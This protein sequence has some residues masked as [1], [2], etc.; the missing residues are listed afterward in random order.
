MSDFIHLNC[1]SEYSVK[2]GTIR[3][4]QLVDKAKKENFKAVAIT[5]YFNLSVAIKF[6]N[7]AISK[8]IKPIFGASIVVLEDKNKY[9]ISLLCQN[10]SGYLNLCKLISEC[11]LYHQD[12][13]SIVAP[14]ELV[15]KYNNG[16]I[17][18]A[19]AVSC[20]IAQ[21]LLDDKLDV[22]YKKV[23]LWQ[24]IFT[25]RYY[26]GVKRTNLLEDEKHLQLTLPLAI[27]TKTP[28]VATN[29]V[30]FLFK[31]DFYAYEARV[32][33][34]EG[35]LLDDDRRN[36]YYSSEQYL[37]SAQKMSELFS[38]IPEAIINSYQIAIRCNVVFDLY[39]K[40]YY[41]PK[42]PLP[43]GL[44]IESFLKKSSLLGLK[45]RLTGTELDFRAYKKRLEYELGV[46]IK[47]KF[48]GYFLIVADFIDFSKKSNI[49]VG[50]GRGS[51]A[52]SLVAY[53]LYITNVDPIRHGLLFERFLNPERISMPD[54]DIDFCTDR[55]DDVIDYVTKKYGKDKV[56]QIIT[57]GTM[58]AKAVVRD[59]GRVLGHPYGF[60]DTLAK[61][62]PNDL[63]ITLDKALEQSSELRDKYSTIEDVK[64]LIDV[65]KKLEGLSRN[66][67]THAGGVVIAPSN[68]SDFCPIY[69]GS[70]ASDSVVTQFDKDDIEAIG[71]VKFDF[72]G[73]GNLTVIAKT[74]KTLYDTNTIKDKIDLDNIELNDKAVYE[75]LQKA[76][77]TGVFQLESQGMR[78]YLKKLKADSF[79]DIVAMLALYRPGPL[80]SG[81][82]DDYINVKHGNKIAQYPHKMLEDILQ[83]TN[84]VFVYQEQVMQ[85]AQKMAGYSLGSADLLRRVMGKKQVKEMQKQRSVFVE[86]ALKKGIIIEKANEIFDL[87]DKFS[88][89]GFNKSHSVAYALISY[90]TAFLKVHYPAAFMSA[91]LSGVMQDTTRVATIVG[92]IKNMSLKVIAPSVNTSCYEFSISGS[93]IIYGLGAIKGL[94]RALANEIVYKRE[95]K[96]YKDLVDFCCRINRNLLNKRAV[97]TLILSGSFDTIC[98][99]R[100]ELLFNYPD[101]IL[102]A[103]RFQQDS[104]T[105]QI[106]LFISDVNLVPYKD[107]KTITKPWQ[108]KEQLKYEKSVMGYYFSSHPC[109][110]EVELAKQISANLPST[111]RIRNNSPVKILGLVANIH[112]RDTKF[113]QIATFDLVDASLGI[114]IF[115]S[116]K[117]LS[118]METS[119]AN[120]DIIVVNGIITKDSKENWQVKVAKLLT[121][122]EVKI[123]Q[124]KT[125]VIKLE[126][127]HDKNFTNLSKLIKQYKGECP[128]Y[129]QY[130][131]NKSIGIIPLNEEYNA[132]PSTELQSKIN[133]LLKK[134]DAVLLNY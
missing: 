128:V 7:Y 113:G 63:G 48:A 124:I 45:K 97:E 62:I 31:Q 133:N 129:L 56:T 116:S 98:A 112:Y 82:V 94:G 71:L 76:D 77:T 105:G 126:T 42:F 115:L 74:L 1:L 118:S 21:L 68:I 47:M 119:I 78:A 65:S 69:K 55:R 107:I 64:H 99:N 3:V 92:E 8:K 36:K 50:P 100:K 57:Y 114:T 20:D 67:G 14:F 96:K 52:G 88:G 54:F 39:K 104:E 46:I 81:M 61:L 110:T 11:Y 91:V 10:Y 131:T 80:E 130:K 123:S 127:V 120:D 35:S 121:I 43:K 4:K 25:N 28:V 60:S 93:D 17:V 32:C 84:G 132:T 122:D 13:K 73:L 79:E 41:L 86:G 30:H 117:V 51:G 102:Q 134:D 38:D 33:I 103:E 29:E 5:D 53:A 19:S 75:L 66:I 101:V 26:L 59:V 125:M 108:P 58:A 22:A 12:L 6:Y 24:E 34:A 9:K 18:I 23:L 37:K 90:Q 2:N 85:A 87:I 44:T 95:G 49:P 111:I 15:K 89:Y 70:N 40:H 106:G 83:P 72:L 27:K 16:L 109:D